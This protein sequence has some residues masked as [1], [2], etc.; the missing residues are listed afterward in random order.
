MSITSGTK[1]CEGRITSDYLP[2]ESRGF[3]DLHY[4]AI[5]KCGDEMTTFNG[6]DAS[7]SHDTVH[8]TIMK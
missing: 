2:C 5:T 4:A 6:N 3:D 8:P 1:S 7:K